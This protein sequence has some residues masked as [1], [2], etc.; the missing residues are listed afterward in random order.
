[1]P[2]DLSAV[3][4]SIETAQ[5]LPN[6]FYVSDELFQAERSSI[7]FPNWTAIG[8]GKDVA[9]PGD[10]RPVDFMGLPL[11]MVRDKEGQVRVYNNVCRHRGMILVDQP[12]RMSGVIRCPYHSWCYDLNGKLRSTPHVG[13]PSINAHEAVKRDELGLK[14]VRSHV[15]CDIVFV[16]VAGDA[17]AFRDHAG[18]LIARWSDYQQALHHGGADSSFKLDLKA[19][20]KL[21]VDNYCESYHLPWVH[22]GL[23]SYS[24][25]ED[26]YT[27][28]SEHEFSGQGTLV[29]NPILDASGREFARFSGLDAKWDRAAEYVALYPNVLLGVHKDHFFAVILEPRAPGR[30]IEHAEIYYADQAMLGDDWASLRKKNTDLWKA[31]FAEDISVCEGM[32]RGRASESFDGG[33]FSPVMDGGVHCFHKWVA[34]NMSSAVAGAT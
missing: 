15:W 16:N 7:F 1:M 31:V 27:I 9:Q 20:W 26:H 21:G 29:Y 10:A 18:T 6:A 12:T 17:P 2:H 13:G 19:N 11:L 14:E 5:G 8:F 3:R 23:S 33:R 32:Q 34:K 22:P 25:L 4:R 30:T 28:A 24:R